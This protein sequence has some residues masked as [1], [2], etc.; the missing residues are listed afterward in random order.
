MEEF[1]LAKIKIR[2]Q[3]TASILEKIKKSTQARRDFVHV[4]S[5]NPE[6]I[7]IARTDGKFK[8]VVESAQIQILDGIGVVWASRIL[9]GRQFDRMTGTDL[10]QEL[11]E[12]AGVNSF[13]VLLIGG[14]PKIAHTIADCYSQKYQQAR[15]LGIE[16]ISD[17]KKPRLEE[18][19][20]IFDIVA[21]Y[22]PHIV[23]VSFGSPDQEVWIDTHKE[24]FSGCVCVGVG[25][26]FD[27]ISG[28]VSRAPS[29]MRAFG[30]EWLYRLVIQPWRLRRQV[31]LIWF[32]L[33]VLY[34]KISSMPRAS[35][36]QE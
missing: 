33:L 10:A 11:L 5:I 30:L 31:N 12:W 6:N 3:T 8:K 24:K 28:N 29:W 36:T 25:G 15:Y 19:K 20:A 1:L 21:D 7:I 4:V 23:L 34:E 9:H 14:M 22:K 16:G 26:A 32:V 27:F 18:E 17:I 13:R 2:P 35:G